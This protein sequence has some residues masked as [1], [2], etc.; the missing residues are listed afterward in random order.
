MPSGPNPDSHGIFFSVNELS[1][2]PRQGS[3]PLSTPVTN[4]VQRRPRQ[5]LAILHHL[6][7]EGFGVCRWLSAFESQHVLDRNALAHHAPDL[8]A[9][10]VRAL[11]GTLLEH[12]HGA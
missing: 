1:D 7:Q 4:F 8:F 9:P 12:R 11:A 2:V 6:T 3:N 5:P 10:R